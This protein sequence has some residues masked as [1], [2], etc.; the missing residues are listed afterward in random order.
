MTDTVRGAPIEIDGQFET[1]TEAKGAP[2]YEPAPERTAPPGPLT[3]TEGKSDALTDLGRF[4]GTTALQAV[5]AVPGAV[6]ALREAAAMPVIYAK[7]KYTGVPY[8]VVAAEH[9]EKQKKMAGM[10]PGPSTLNAPTPEDVMHWIASQGTGEY[11]PESATGR[12]VMSGLS[13]AM[14]PGSPLVGAQRV[15][16]A[17]VPITPP[18]KVSDYTRIMAPA[19]VSGAAAT[20]VGEATGDPIVAMLAGQATGVGTSFGSRAVGA[21]ITHPTEL[22]ERTAGRA[23]R[24]AAA[25]GP[26]GRE[27]LEERLAGMPGES[28]G[29]A[30]E[31]LRQIEMARQRAAQ[32][33][34]AGLKP[35]V[36]GEYGLVGNAPKET[37]ASDVRTI[38]NDAYNMANTNVQ[39]L[40]QQPQLQSA[41]MYR[42]KSIDP[43][44]ADIDGLSTPRQQAIPKEVS[45]TIAAIKQRHERDIPLLEMQDLRSQILSA[46]REAENKGNG[47]GA[48]VLGELAEKLR[49]TLSDEKNIVFGDSTGAARKQWVDAVAATKSLHDTFKVGRLADIVGSDEAKAKVAFNDTLR[50]LLNRPDGARNAMLLQKSLGP[51]V[52]THLADYLIGDMT[53]NGTRVVTPKEVAAYL[54]KKGDLV[55]KVPGARERFE[56][57]GTTSAKDQLL[58]NIDRNVGNADALVEIANKNRSLINSLPPDERAQLDMIERGARAALRVDPDRTTPLRTLDALARGTTSDVLYGA[59]TGRI[60][61]A[62]LAYGAIQMIAHQLGMGDMVSGMLGHTGAA[63][64]AGIVGP[65]VGTAARRM[66]YLPNVPEN[67]LSGQVQTIAVELLQRARV[68]PQLRA[69]LETKPDL[70]GLTYYAPALPAAEKGEEGALEKARQRPPLARASG[71]RIGKIDHAGIAASLIRAAEKAKKG[72]STTT[73]PLLEQPDEAIT[74]ALAIANK[75]LE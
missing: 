34:V 64:A 12:M 72:H 42:N 55:D 30:N 65:A 32:Q 46:A 57:I 7:S 54:G 38:F 53:N 69:R 23:Y 35:D 5:S 21:N 4:L 8:D 73:E 6:G 10:L 39:S 44:I 49:T 29:L 31:Q 2:L 68:D 25:R 40:W 60:R 14:V 17:P 16:G 75:A 52:D 22:A 1:P 56:T 36:K 27:Y 70:R 9:R 45:D 67:I 41:T 43:L 18:T 28:A 48:Q 20:A 61:D 24:E 63:V 58:A 74:K 37:A 11:I 13:S 51:G 59:L 66:P 26:A 62:T 15:R 19:G 47:F 33:T 71:G 50:Y 3:R